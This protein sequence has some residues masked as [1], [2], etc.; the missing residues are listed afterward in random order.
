[1]TVRRLLSGPRVSAGERRKRRRRPMMPAAQGPSGLSY[2]HSDA[3]WTDRRCS[4][5]LRVE[6]VP[7]YRLHSACSE[8]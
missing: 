7:V 2:Q 5:S 8:T 4:P 1:M 3:S 6:D